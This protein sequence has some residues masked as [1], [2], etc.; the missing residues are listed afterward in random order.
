[1]GFLIVGAILAG[2]V[3]LKQPGHEGTLILAAVSLGLGA[4]ALLFEWSVVGTVD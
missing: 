1:M 2:S 3:R 4:W